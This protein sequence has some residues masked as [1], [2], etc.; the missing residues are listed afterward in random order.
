MLRRRPFPLLCFDEE[1]DA[2]QD[3]LVAAAAALGLE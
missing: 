3:K 2:L 1:P